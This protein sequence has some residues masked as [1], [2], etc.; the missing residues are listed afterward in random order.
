MVIIPNSDIILLKSPLK[1]DNYNQITFNN[2]NDQYNYFYNLPK[3]SIS[4]A[5]YVRKDN[6]I[7]YPTHT[8]VNDGLPTFEDL[9]EYNYCM[10]RN[11]SYDNK[12]FYA[13]ITDISYQNDGVSYITI[14][15]DCFQSWQFDITY[16]NSFIEREHVS[17]DTIG[18]HTLPEN[19][20]LGEYISNGF[21]RDNELNNLVYVIQVTEW[22]NG[23][24]QKP[25][26]TNY[27]G[28]FA[29]GGAYICSNANEVAQII[30]AYQNGREEA[31]TNVYIVPA[32]IVNNTN[33]TMQYSGQNSPVTYNIEIDKQ[34][35][36]NGYTPK[37]NKLLTYP[38]NFLV[39]DNNNG[40]SNVLQYELFSENKATFE[41]AGVPTVGGS[42][43]CVPT[44]Y[45]GETR[46]Q[47][48]GLMCGKFPTC[49]W[50]T[51]VYT[52]WLTQ[53]AVN[54]GVGI[55]SDSL[56]ILSGAAAPSGAGTSQVIGGG[57]GIARTIGQIYQHSILPNSAK[58]NTNGGDIN[59]CYEMNK[60]YFI[61]QS[62][63]YETA[64]I[65]DNFF[66]MY[67][68]KVN[69]LATPNIHK[70]SNWDYIKCID[71]N[72]EGN[73]P[74]KDLDKIRS[75]FNNGCTFWHTTSNYLNYSLNNNIL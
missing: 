6:V 63:K 45:K 36:L 66:T 47:Q 12:W 23:S 59:T 15:T 75:L 1:L 33:E 39:I 49:G 43:K 53:N 68:Y 64:Q 60:F 2:I 65:I 18:L 38:Y 9:L 48:E 44:N 5:T 27:G 34:S 11:T 32:K 54:I 26:A 3:L 67:G 74:E 13:F 19:L 8:E 35:T 56:T 73:I 70:R 37:N 52:N 40:S 61:K 55:A 30:Q 25:L 42:I 69:R 57:L 58:G 10:Y 16:M 28:V 51:D 72:L 24:S 41:V 4:E 46:Y 14:E 31:V 7:R 17:N 62:I 22:V 50:V 29:P 71:V 20:E 21:V